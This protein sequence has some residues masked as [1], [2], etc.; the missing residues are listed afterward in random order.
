[1]SGEKRDRVQRDRLIAAAAEAVRDGTPTVTG[2]VRRAGVGRNT[3]YRFFRS[4]DQLIG[5]LEHSVVGAMK[6]ALERAIAE[7]HTPAGRLSA[8]MR[9]WFAELERRH[10]AVRALLRARHQ[11]DNL[12]AVGALLLHLLTNVAREA[13]SEAAMGFNAVDDFT[14]LCAAGAVEAIARRHLAAPIRDVAGIAHDVVA[15][16]LR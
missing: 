5:E 10:V 15:K 3:F 4:P 2:I 6:L 12:S 11:S 9:V 7:S 8:L 14:L 16:L 13:R 1:L